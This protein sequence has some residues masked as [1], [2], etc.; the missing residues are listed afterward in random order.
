MKINRDIINDFKQWKDDPRRKPIL[1]TGS[2]QIGKRWAMHEFGKECFGGKS[3][4][5]YDNKYHPEHRIRF[6]M[7]N[8]QSNGNLLSCPAPLAQWAFQWI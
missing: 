8:L 7:L 5:V 3:L 4:S 6:S 1:L 2:R